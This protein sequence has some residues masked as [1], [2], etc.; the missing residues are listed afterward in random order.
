MR[1]YRNDQVVVALGRA[2]EAA[3]Y[4]EYVVPFETETSLLPDVVDKLVP[5]IDPPQSA[6]SL[7][8]NSPFSALIG[9]HH[10]ELTLSVILP[11]LIISAD[12]MKFEGSDHT[13]HDL[14]LD[15]IFRLLNMY[16]FPVLTNDHFTEE[17]VSEEYADTRLSIMELELI[18]VSKAS[19]DQILSVRQDE[20]SWKDLRNFRTFIHKNYAG[21]ELAFVED[22]IERIIDKYNETAKRLGFETKQTLWEVLFNKNIVDSGR[23]LLSFF[24]GAGTAGLSDIVAGIATSLGRLVV[25]LDKA[26]YTINSELDSSPVKYIVDARK[27]LSN[28][29][30]NKTIA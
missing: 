16:A 22:E 6:R 4:F 24:L 21:K 11:G 27:K 3:L 1:K 5:D 12:N 18:D 7:L 10:K 9:P 2:K 15:D 23:N 19:W 28:A 13:F 8:E 14:A 25:K 17:R 30:D 20:S 26:K 29:D